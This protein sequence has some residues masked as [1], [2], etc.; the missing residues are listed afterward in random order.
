MDK[1]FSLGYYKYIPSFR[2]FEVFI[3]DVKQTVTDLQ[4]VVTLFVKRDGKIY[5]KVERTHPIVSHA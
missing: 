1:I 2:I 4:C 3:L 5:I